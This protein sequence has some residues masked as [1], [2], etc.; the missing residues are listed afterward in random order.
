MPL[1]VL[2]NRR[3]GHNGPGALYKPWGDVLRLPVAED[4]LLQ[5]RDLALENYT[6]PVGLKPPSRP[7]VV[8]LTRQDTTRRLT[9]EA[10]AALILALRG[11]KTEGLVDFHILNFATGVDFR[12]QV[13]HMVNIDVSGSKET[14]GGVRLPIC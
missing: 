7:R 9:D 1:V 5:L 8:Y 6:G 3:A 11:L 4:Y 10:N 14:Q 2:A 12:D 13:A